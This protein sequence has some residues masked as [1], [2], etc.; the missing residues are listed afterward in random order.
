MYLNAG[1]HGSTTAMNVTYS[2]TRVSAVGNTAG[3]GE[4]GGADLSIGGYNASIDGVTLAMADTNF[5][6]NLAG[7]GCVCVVDGRWSVRVG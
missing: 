2:L 7:R 5:S 6:N 3:Q 1:G 4:G